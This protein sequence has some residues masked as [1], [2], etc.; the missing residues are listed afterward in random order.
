M[1]AQYWTRW[2][3]KFIPLEMTKIDNNTS[4]FTKKH[5]L[6]TDLDGV[7][8]TACDARLPGQPSIN[9][10]NSD[11][12]KEFLEQ[13]LMCMELEAVSNHL[14]IMSTQSSSN[15]NPLHYQRVKGRQ[16]L[17]AED[18]RLHLVWLHDRIFLKPLPPYLL[19]YDFWTHFLTPQSNGDAC[20]KIRKTAL[21]FLRTYGHLI[22][23]ES[24]FRIARQESLQLIPPGVTW[25]DFSKFIK[26]ISNI[27]DVD[28][29]G[30]Y[31]YGELR[32]ARLNFYAP[33]L[34]HRSHFEQ[35]YSEYSDYFSRFYA[36]LLFGFAILST[37]LNSMQVELAVEQLISKDWPAFW[38]LCRWISTICII[39]ITLLTLCILGLWLRLVLD[40]WVYAFTARWRKK[41]QPSHC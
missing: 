1:F 20:V 13:D 10:Q 16:I 7:D 3:K 41:R 26:E 29:S 40:E 17:I 12:V 11:D 6:C 23:H 38:S 33:F 24:D 37:I 18:P 27:D 8:F 28:V 34:F 32:L 30:R 31:Q 39:F 36:P 15:I 2:T 21:G 25:P 4:V 5:E 9:L 14:W 19:S 35:A 22:Q